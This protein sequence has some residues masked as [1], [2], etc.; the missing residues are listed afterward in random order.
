MT[1]GTTKFTLKDGIYIISFLIAMG[2]MVSTFSSR[3]AVM[4]TE[5]ERNA[6]LLETYNLPVFDYQLGEIDNKLENL[7][8]LLEKHMNE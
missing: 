4:E 6:L 1:N 2:A 3:I 8:D 7:T 5:V